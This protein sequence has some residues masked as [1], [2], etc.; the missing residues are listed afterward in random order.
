MSSRLDFKNE[1]IANYFLEVKDIFLKN[2]KFLT[3]STLLF[4]LIGIIYS[5]SLN[6]KFSVSSIIVSN[7]PDGDSQ[8][9]QL[10]GLSSLLNA[11][12]PTTKLDD[13]VNI[14]KAY[15]T[16]EYLWDLGYDTVFFGFYYDEDKG[17]YP[18]PP[19]DLWQR[20]K[21]KILGYDLD[22]LEKEFGPLD[23]KNIIN[24][25][26]NITPLE[27]MLDDRKKQYGLR[28]S[29]TTGN[30]ELAKKLIP[31][32]L[33]SADNVL[34]ETRIEYAEAQVSFL[35]DQLQTVED[36]DIRMSFID[37]MKGHYRQLALL[38]SD[39]PFSYKVI[40][41]PTVS[42]GPVYPN[43]KFIY[44]FFP[45][46]GFSLSFLYLYLRKLFILETD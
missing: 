11:T 17:I 31:D 30:P 46:I 4:F 28:V 36:S 26:L 10:G 27:Y 38:S 9:L 35:K 7:Q 16:A 42:D 43:L 13:L 8:Q 3:F 21:S 15:P 1:K 18:K 44:I 5:F 25:L 34:K 41:G 14:I 23:L 24:S 22:I 39:L 32:L 6:P 12:A 19:P 37:I 20:I 2:I 29:M 33:T 40:E 45:F